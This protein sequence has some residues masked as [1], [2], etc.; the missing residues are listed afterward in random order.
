[1]RP[2]NHGPERAEF[3]GKSNILTRAR[4]ELERL[5]LLPRRTRQISARERLKLQA[6]FPPMDERS[7][8]A[9]AEPPFGDGNNPPM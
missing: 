3:V 8:D 2:D 6:L 4:R 7:R 5:A 1:M 9:R